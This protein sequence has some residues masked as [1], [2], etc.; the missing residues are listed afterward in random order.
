MASGVDDLIPE[1][2]PEL[3]GK[4]ED[5]LFDTLNFSPADFLMIERLEK[6][7]GLLTQLREQ[8]EQGKEFVRTPGE[9]ELMNAIT[10]YIKTKKITL[11]HFKEMVEH[12]RSLKIKAEEGFT[13]QELLEM[14]SEG[15][16]TNPELTKKEEESNPKEEIEEFGPA[17]LD[18]LPEFKQRNYKKY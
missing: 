9:T 14:I 11:A 17:L 4:R 5:L 2:I 3:E 12:F 16:P 10:S 13:E 1:K 8:G 6:A 7:V 15:L 18:D